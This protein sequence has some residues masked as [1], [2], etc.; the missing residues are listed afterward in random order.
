MN[1]TKLLSGRQ[2]KLHGSDLS[3]QRHDYLDLANAEPDLGIPSADDAVLVGQ[4]DGTREWSRDL[5][6]DSI[7]ADIFT[8]LIDSA[9][10]SEIV[11]TPGVRFDSDVTVGN[12]LFSNDI[13]SANITV[14]GNATITGNLTVRGTT[15][16]VS[17]TTIEIGDV[18]ITLASNATNADDADGAGITINGPAVPAT[19][20]YDSSTDTWNLN[21]DLN[22][23][24]ITSTYLNGDLTGNVTGNITGNVFT[25][26][27][28]SADSS[29][30]NIIPSV[31]INSDLTVENDLTVSN[32][33]TAG[34]FI[35]DV[36]GQ[37][38]DITN[39][40]VGSL[41]DV[42]ITTVP[43][44]EGQPLIWSSVAEAF[45]PGGQ[46]L[47]ELSDVTFKTVTVDELFTPVID[48]PDSSLITII[49]AVIAK[50]DVI[51]E[52][53]LFV[54]NDINIINGTIR[55][56]TFTGDLIG[57]VTGNLTG[58]VTGTFTGDAFVGTID[59][60]DSS[61][62]DIVPFV[63]MY[64]DLTVENDLNVLNYVN[65]YKDIT[66]SG[67]VIT[68][69]LTS[70]DSF[71][72]TIRPSLDIVSDLSVGG[73][74]TVSGIVVGKITD[75]SNHPLGELSNVND[76]ARQNGQFLVW[77]SAQQKWITGD[78]FNQG[79]FDTA[80]AAS[81]TDD[82]PEGFINLY[83]TADRARNAIDNTSRTLTN[84]TLTGYLR[85]PSTFTIDP[86]AFDD[87]TG[88][89]VIAGNLQVD[90][91]TTTIN[92]TTV[93]IDDKNIVL[94][95]GSP[96]AAA[97]D[98]AGITIDIGNTNTRSFYYDAADDKFVLDTY[99]D[100]Q[101]TSLRPGAISDR[102]DLSTSVEAG[103]YILIYDSSAGDLKKATIADA[104][105]QGPAGYT[106]SKGDIGY[107]G[108]QGDLGYTGSQGDI[109]YTGS[110]GVDGYAGSIG[111]TG[112][113][114]EDGYQGVDGYTGSIGYTGSV[115]FV[116]SR[117]DLGYTGSQ[118][119]PGT[120]VRI[121]GS[122][123][124]SSQLPTAYSGTSTFVFDNPNG[125][126][127]YTV[128]G[129]VGNYPTLIVHR[130]YTYTFDFIN[131]T[132]SHPIALRL[133]SQDTSTVPGTTG[134]D[135]VNGVYGS[136]A[137]V[138]Y[139]VP[140]NAPNSIVYQCV[141]HSSM[142]GS[143]VI[144]TSP[145]VGDGY[146]TQ[147]TGH[148]WVWDGSQWNDVGQI[149]GFTGSRGY[150][151]S[152]GADGYTGS[153]GFTGSQGAGYTG[154][155]GDL[156]YTGSIGFTGS[157]GAGFVGSA[158]ELGYTGSAGEGYTGSQGNVGYTGSEGYTGSQGESS[159]T[160][161]V[162]PPVNPEIGDRWYDTNEGVLLTYLDDGDSQQ[163]VE[164]YASGFLGNTGY[165][166]SIGF[167]GST[168]AYAAVGFT[169]SSGYTGSSGGVNAITTFPT[170]INSDVTI[171]AGENAL[172]VGPL[173]QATGTVITITAGQ[174]WI[175]L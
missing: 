68:S 98:G 122:V 150:D 32:I 154:S 134:N 123:S 160:W 2:K 57:N 30:I 11:F 71:P 13:T 33:V 153:I 147:D 69:E 31:V 34:R 55:A 131:V 73:D 3:P 140:T 93:E 82:L 149:T 163:W 48:S 121:V 124:D 132:S 87:N 107:T 40:S 75:I 139:A 142:I 112:S 157:R 81:T 89:V 72:I 46:G 88:T 109:G 42:D 76:S 119:D 174:R 114:G 106:G 58:S 168:G 115:G 126:F 171:A 12:N 60:A 14:D 65:V 36:T 50:S 54:V 117:G 45:V 70:S 53:D 38:S 86:A 91:T 19:I 83:F 166:G 94:A 103:D 59:S 18:N 151:G 111:F 169:G 4:T 159:F 92:S 148:L 133:S 21:K 52:N 64:S 127:S 100:A 44:E 7:T 167:T 105:L 108:S 43:P 24:T 61:G 16:T 80:L 25:T 23:N 29:T 120:S 129:Y 143:I 28:D 49:P 5:D 66:V 77:S 152:A 101:V 138:T 90:G 113:K 161:G 62:I 74:I 95:A 135:P 51:V 9:D 155:A 35:G 6:I 47:T 39:H 37:I 102:T 84:L 173:T 158:G 110:K 162:T 125:G 144:Q 175:I 85:G 63:R 96:N 97:A 128:N 156:G 99:L 118:G 136:G 67:R 27:I 1:R 164:V 26:Q 165:T 146:I 172:S 145:N 10:S 56:N 78:G 104:A 8:N 15:T 130:G 41:Y 79:D 170:A 137:T 17:S 116:G 141:L 20:V 22:V